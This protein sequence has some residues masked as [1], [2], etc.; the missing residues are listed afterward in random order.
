M[1]QPLNSPGS[2]QMR[3]RGIL[4]QAPAALGP[5]LGAVVDNL[6]SLIN[7]LEH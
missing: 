5:H 6:I 7:S 4:S 1:V 2:T 3:L